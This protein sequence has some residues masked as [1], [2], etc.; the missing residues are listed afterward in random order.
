NYL[1]AARSAYEMGNKDEAMRLLDQA[2][3]TIPDSELAVALTRAQ[4]ELR[5]KEYDQCHATLM[6]IKPK[7]PQNPVLLDLLYRVH[8]ARR[9]W[10]G[11][12]GI[13]DRLRNHK[14]LPPQELAQL[15]IRI[16]SEQLRQ[17]SERCQQLVRSE[18]LAC[19]KNAWNK[20]PGSLQKR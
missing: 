11:L 5:N 7:A 2:E 12:Q 16:H 9:D 6:H 3:T 4:I 13:F 20:V 18:R 19:L 8:L 15:E 1:A 10:A 14:I 17:E